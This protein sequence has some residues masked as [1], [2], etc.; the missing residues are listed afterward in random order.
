VKRWRV[1]GL[2]AALG[3]AGWLV[4]VSVAIGVM[5]KGGKLIEEAQAEWPD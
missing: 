4:A 5:V 2:I 3:V 1:A